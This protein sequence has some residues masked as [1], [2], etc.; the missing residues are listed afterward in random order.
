MGWVGHVAH[1]GE[2]SGACRRLVGKPE[3]KKPHWRPGFEWYNTEMGLQDMWLVGLYWNDMSKIELSGRLLWT[4]SSSFWKAKSLNSV[5]VCI[6]LSFGWKQSTGL[7][8][9][10]SGISELDCATTKADTAERSIS[11]GRESLQV[12]FCTRGLGVLPG[13]TARG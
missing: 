7:F 6:R 12:F 1:M 5:F 4:R 10:P 2:R 3:G 9:C 11:I 8:I 13:S